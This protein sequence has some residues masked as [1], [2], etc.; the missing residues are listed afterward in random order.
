V[1]VAREI[2]QHLLGPGE[3]A[4]GVDVPLGV[5]ERLQP[6]LERGLVSEPA[7]G[8]KNCRRPASY[9]VFSIAS[10]LPRNRRESTGTGK[11]KSS[12][13]LIHCDPSSAMPPPGTIM[14]TCGWCVI[15]EP[16]V[17]S[18]EVKPILTP[19]RLGSDAIVSSVSALRLEQEIVD[20]RLVLMRD[21]ADPRRQREHDVEV[22]APPATRPC[23]LPSI[24][25][26]GCPGT[27]GN[28]D[29]G[30]CCKRWPCA[31]IARSARHGRRG[32][33]C[34]NPRLRSSP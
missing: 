33:P 15:A 29:C 18:T 16:H 23:A 12:E 11:R 3:R 30:S 10:I 9:A 22:G 7:C 31:G 34:G 24:H 6:C 4:L 13:Q 21:R 8:P 25:A 26:L 14:C 19:S 20:H 1:R 17:C 2:G 28:A 27:S 32:P 5:V